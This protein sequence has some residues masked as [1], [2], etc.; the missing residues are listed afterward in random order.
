[1]TRYIPLHFLALAA[2]FASTADAEVSYSEAYGSNEGVVHLTITPAAAP[3]PTLRYRLMQRDLD[4]KPGNAAPYYYRTQ[5]EFQPMMNSLREQFNEDNELS[6]WYSTGT[7]A[8]PIDKLP[9]DKVR[10]ANQMFDPIYNGDL[11]TAF[12][13]STCDWQLSLEEKGPEIISMRLNEIQGSRQVARMISLRARL[14]IA[15]RRYDDAVK[16]LRENY[17]LGHD[18]AQVPF[19][20]CS[21]VGIAIDQMTNRT[22]LELIASPD[23]PN[24]YWALSQ[25]PN[26]PIDMQRAAR[27]EMDLGPRMFPFIDN[28]ETTDH[29]PQE[30]GRLLTKAGRD[31]QA[32][33]SG[34]PSSAKSAEKDVVDGLMATGLSLTGYTRAKVRL[35]A[36]GMDR[37]RVE[38]MPVGQVIAVYTERT[39][40]RFA[41]EWENLWQMPYAQ[42]KEMAKRLDKKIE[43]ARPLSGGKDTEIFPMVSMLMPA[44]SACRAAEVRLERDMAALRVIEALRMY[45]ADHDG[46]L[47]S[48]LADIEEVP[49]PTN[50]ATGKPFVYRLDGAKAI[51]E[52][53]PSDQLNGGNCRYEIQIAAKK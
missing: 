24:M 9:L 42:S 16:T 3:A 23:S 49:V 25:I 50:P 11:K 10:Q 32:A 35:I 46:Q 27:F 41:N 19:L 36:D 40:Y 51:L 20:V 14:A 4:L 33:G 21:L 30:W 15:E 29:S 12:E 34:A 7:G 43:A 44:L 37:S 2:V 39:Y 17:R 6:L 38:H 47:P 28:A 26:P 13:R 8:T 31:L 18:T 53:P 1:M 52:L 5:L 22:L 45:A 48:R